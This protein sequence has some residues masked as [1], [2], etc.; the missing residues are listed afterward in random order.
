MARFLWLVLVLGC[1]TSRPGAVAERLRDCGL[2]TDGHVQ[3]LPFYAPDSCY[4]GCLAEA[5]CG[6]LERELC[7]ASI[8]LAV[9]CDERC[10]HRC[11][12]GGFIAPENFCDGVPQ[13]RDG[14]DEMGC[15]PPRCGDGT[16]LFRWQLCDGWVECTD[17]SDEADC[18]A[19]CGSSPRPPG[20]DF[21]CADG[22]TVSSFT[23]CDGWEACRDGSDEAGC[24]ELVA[25]CEP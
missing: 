19:T 17:G 16:E 6:E 15:E 14:S 24:A 22:T 12:G 1:S 7:G 23:R 5:S 2:L 10:A 9:R 13:C 20:C 8:D 18:P 4:E 21:Q 25:T 11:P 3:S